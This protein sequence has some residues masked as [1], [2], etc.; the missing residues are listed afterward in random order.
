ML[1]QNKPHASISLNFD[2]KWSYM[3][4]YKCVPINLDNI[5]ES[6]RRRTPAFL[7]VSPVNISGYPTNRLMAVLRTA[8][9]AYAKTSSACSMCG[10]KN[11]S[12]PN[13]NEFDLQAQID[14]VVRILYQYPQKIEQIDLL[15]LGSFFD[16]NEIT[17]NFRRFALAK[18]ND[19]DFIS[20][21]VVES[22]AAHITKQK[23]DDT[24]SALGLTGSF[25]CTSLLLTAGL[26][27]LPG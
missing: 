20:K 15:T 8:G 22:R 5:D 1:S 25:G 4:K 19:I 9:C 26:T 17:P 14:Y 11:N 16:N 12:D 13:V 10:F 23:L 3:N 21:V 24:R 7:E 18:I 27:T 6:D 2:D